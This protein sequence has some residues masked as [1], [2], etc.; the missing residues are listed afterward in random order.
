MIVK[1]SQADILNVDQHLLVIISWGACLNE[2]L[3]YLFIDVCASLIY[4]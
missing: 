3:R 2:H 1:N 4:S